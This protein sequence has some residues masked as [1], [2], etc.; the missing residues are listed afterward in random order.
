MCVGWEEKREGVKEKREERMC[1]SRV[2]GKRGREG[3]REGERRG[4]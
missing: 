3:E 1:V 4:G 2:N